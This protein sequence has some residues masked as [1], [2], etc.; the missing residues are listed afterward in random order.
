M[1][2]IYTGDGKGKT[3]ASIGMII[4]ALGAGKKVAFY[5]FLKDGKSSEIK[6]LSKLS[7]L[8]VLEA[9]E[10]IEEVWTYSKEKIEELKPYYNEKLNQI[11]KAIPDYDMV[12]LD[13]FLVA[14]NYGY[15]DYDMAYEFVKSFP[16]DKELVITGRG[17]DEKF[18]DLCDYVSRIDK[19]KHP[20]DNGTKAREGIEY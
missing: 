1:K 12:V 11:S 9:L 2:H 3:T 15:L 14:L 18:V 7:N 4:R 19:V 6:I 17:E 16:D 10:N 13:E 5:Q 20:Y 8:T